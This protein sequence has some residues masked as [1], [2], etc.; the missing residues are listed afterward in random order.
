MYS[1][2]IVTAAPAEVCTA[3]NVLNNNVE[4]CK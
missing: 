2:Q 4:L 3:V 1:K